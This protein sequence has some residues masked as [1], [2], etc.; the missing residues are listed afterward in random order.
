MLVLFISCGKTKKEFVS[1]FDDPEKMP[2]LK[3]LDVSML[4]S[5]SGVTRYRVKT[6]E[7]L[8][9]DKAKEPYQYFPQGIYVENFDSLFNV[10]SYIQADTAYFYERP[11]LWELIGNVEM[12]NVQQQKFQTSHL[13]WDQ[14]KQILYNDVFIRIEKEDQFL[15]G[16]G[17]ESNERMTRY[18]IR[19]PGP[20]DFTIKEQPDS[21]GVSQPDSVPQDSIMKTGK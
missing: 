4:I 13:F 7:W 2:T 1:S 5:D 12:K 3:T 18:T 8:M 16:Y 11:K 19:R 9:F 21:T 10:V 20:G 17:F 15:E 14:K 6:K